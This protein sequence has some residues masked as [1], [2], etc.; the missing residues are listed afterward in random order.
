MDRQAAVKSVRE[1][2]RERERETVRVRERCGDVEPWSERQMEG[3]A[4]QSNAHFTPCC[5][6]DTKWDLAEESTLGHAKVRQRTTWAD[7]GEV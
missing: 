3:E 4:F 2:E 7:K 5:S 1:R 6:D